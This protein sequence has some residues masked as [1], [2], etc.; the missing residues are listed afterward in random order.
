MDKK[1]IDLLALEEKDMKLLGEPTLISKDLILNSNQTQPGKERLDSNSSGDNIKLVFS[2]S[3]FFFIINT[4]ND[5]E[6]A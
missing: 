3:C 5:K 4:T 1:N 6:S 2:L